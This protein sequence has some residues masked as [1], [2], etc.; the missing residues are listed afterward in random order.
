MRTKRAEDE[1]RL[2]EQ[3]ALLDEAQQKLADTFKA[4]SS[5]AL[6]RNNKQFLELAQEALSKHHEQAKGELAKREQAVGELVKPLKESLDKM[7]EKVQA[8]EKERTDAYATLRE[9]VLGL[10]QTQQQLR[11]E[12]ARLVTALRAP[13][14]R[15]RWGEVQLRR[16]V[17][18][19]GMVNYC[20]FEEQ[21]TTGAE[22]G[23]L[24]PDMVVRLP[25][26]RRIV[27]DSKAPLQAYLEALEA[28][29]DDQRAECMR[30]HAAQVRTHLRQLG[31]KAY[32]Q[33][34]DFSPEFVVLFLPG[35]T[36][37]SAALQ[38]D[39]G[40]IEH[41]VE[42]GVILATPTTLIALLK[43]VAYG[44]RQEQIA[45]SALVIRQIG[46]ELYR[47]SAIL[48]EHI[49]DVG[50]HLDRTVKSYNRSVGSFESRLFTQV[51]RFQELGAAAGDAIPETASVERT[52]REL[53]A[54]VE[55]LPTLGG[56]GECPL[57]ERPLTERP[58]PEV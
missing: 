57:T 17:E 15:G 33:Q 5:D 21:A 16:V 35:E 53:S 4:L 36:F 14:V 58:L 44:W 55:A 9:Q 31:Q 1:Q 19:A 34:F 39:P 11:D 24:R 50:R 56:D 32:A 6:Q 13:Q 7:N 20:D 29:D 40:L 47:R 30:R 46:E 10:T 2:A 25:N 26:D 54:A 3:K 41:G 48:A 45:E 51:R 37:F 12:T 22:D 43:A 38:H 49:A 18:V 23:R 28:A 52:P 27:V 42:Q 8:V